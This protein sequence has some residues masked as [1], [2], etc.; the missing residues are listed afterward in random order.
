MADIILHSGSFV[1]R[2]D[3]E[4]S[5]T[6][7]KRD[8]APSGVTVDKHE[9]NSLASGGTAMVT[10]TYSGRGYITPTGMPSWLEVR[11]KDAPSS[12]TVRY[13]FIIA[14]NTGGARD[15]TITFTGSMGGSDT[16][17][18][19]QA[20][21]A[22]Q[23][24][25]N[26]SSITNV[27]YM[28]GTYNLSFLATP[29][30]GMFSEVLPNTADWLYV[31]ITSLSAATVMIAENLTTSS[32]SATIMFYKADDHS[33]YLTVNITQYG[34]PA[35]P[36]SVREPSVSF[37]AGGGNVANF[38][39]NVY[40]TLS[41][42]PPSWISITT[43]LPGTTMNIG[44]HAAPNPFTVSRYGSVMFDDD[45]HDPVYMSVEQAGSVPSFIN[46]IQWTPYLSS[47]RFSINSSYYNFSD[48]QSCYFSDFSGTI[49]SSAFYGTKI[50]TLE[51]DARTIY[52]E[53]FASCTSLT[54]ASL[55]QCTYIG[56][57]AFGS[58]RVLKNI[59]IPKCERVEEY[60]FFSCSFPTINLP[61]C[62]Y[63][64]SNAF[65]NCRQLSTIYLGY[66]SVCMMPEYGDVFQG[67][68]I[69][70]SKGSIFVPGSLVSAY[71][72]ESVWSELS[73]R[74]FPIG[75]NSF[76]VMPDTISFGSAQNTSYVNLYNIPS[77]G[78]SDSIEYYG[79]S[80][81]GWLTVVYDTPSTAT[82]IIAYNDSGYERSA[83]VTFFDQDNIDNYTR[84]T[85]IQSA[86]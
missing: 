69:T 23:W 81:G 45:R 12:T 75:G 5:I 32:R 79:Y 13:D 8:S 70:Y 83:R 54:S 26:P 40:G 35:G 3:N 60:G 16:T 46:Y 52:D 72:S 14:Q 77:G 9:I 42:T 66:G 6:F 57:F 76:T 29:N 61:A 2:N 64:G 74:I 41:Y 30:I 20:A 4:I 84:L 18:V 31:N 67:T 47:G 43:S 55:S 24:E 53:A 86:N 34:Y 58:C 11:Y 51:T 1:D 78:I 38:V 63:I 71:K 39:D 68:S 19:N 28:G 49:T 65:A 15:V 22:V 73:N 21:A 7:F 50:T 37:S 44:I 17:T 48:Y 59:S 56:S 10:V 62:S 85:V 80:Y 27:G 82:I 36:L 25:V 33:T